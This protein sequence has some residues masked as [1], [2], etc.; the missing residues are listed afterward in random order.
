MLFCT[1]V[2]SLFAG[3]APCRLVILVKIWTVD[4]CL[5]YF[6]TVKQ[7]FSIF[8]YKDTS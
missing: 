4:S 8:V 1:G 6:V 5:D 7:F 2:I 3:K